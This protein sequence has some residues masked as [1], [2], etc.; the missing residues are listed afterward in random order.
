MRKALFAFP[1]VAAA[2]F[3]T[4]AIA[5]PSYGPYGPYAYSPY[6][7]AAPWVVGAGVG[8][9]AAIAAYNGSFGAAAAGT[10]AAATVGAAA[11]GGTAAI[12]AVALTD[13]VL[14][15]C[16]GFHAIFGL[17]HGACEDGHYV[18]YAPPPGPG[19]RGYYR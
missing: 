14:Q 10:G 6:A 4:P 3:A 15:P 17:N 11:I 16:R 13:A 2:A 1:I 12:G 7:A 9:G 5:Q 8:T 18:G 19:P